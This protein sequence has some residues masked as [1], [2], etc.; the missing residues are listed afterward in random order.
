MALPK[1][2]VIVTTYNRAHMV[3]ETIDSI[4]SQTSKDFELI[5]VDNESIDNTEEVIKSYTDKRIRYFKHQNN[6]IIAVNRNYGIS[7]TQGE[8]IAFCDDDDLW[9]PEK[10][11]RQLSEFEKDSQL[12]LVCSNGIFFDKNGEHREMIKAELKDSDFTFESLIWHNY[13]PSP[14]VLVK[15]EVIDDV[16]MMDESPEI[17]IAEDYELWLR[18]AKKYKVKYIGLPLMKYRTHPGQYTFSQ[19]R[20]EPMELE[21]A[22]CRKLLDTGILDF[23]LYQKRIYRLGHPTLTTRLVKLLAS[24]GILKYI[25]SLLRVFRR[26]ASTAQGVKH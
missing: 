22:V 14:S 16:G 24:I 11:E 25:S 2:S 15:K 23:E 17:F 8:Y 7:K 26:L 18:I 12:G 9:M 21:K 1:I 4:L 6:G 5:V 10:L 19:E 3:T 20:L 13:I